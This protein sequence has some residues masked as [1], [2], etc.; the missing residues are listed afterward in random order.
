M[1]AHHDVEAA[2]AHELRHRRL[3]REGRAPGHRGGSEPAAENRARIE[4]HHD[5][6]PA[7]YRNAP[8]SGESSPL[9]EE[10]ECM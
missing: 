10:M 6:V 8:E 7:R 9:I 5:Q 4:D 3:L 2:V 1:I